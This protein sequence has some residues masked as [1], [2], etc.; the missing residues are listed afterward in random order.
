MSFDHNPTDLTSSQDVFASIEVAGAQY[1]AD[2]DSSSIQLSVSPAERMMQLKEEGVAT[3]KRL[4]IVLEEFCSHEFRFNELTSEVEYQGEALRP[5]YFEEAHHF[6]DEKVLGC[7]DKREHARSAIKYVS[8][9]NSY[10]PV[11]NYLNHVADTVHEEVTAEE[12]CER[13]LGNTHPLVIRYVECWLAGAVSKAVEGQGSKFIEVLTL[14]STLQGIGKS[15]FFK[16]LASPAWFSDSFAEHTG[17]DSILGLHSSWI[18]EI[19]EVD[20]Y[21]ARARDFKGLKSLVSATDDLVRVPYGTIIERR[22]RRFVLGATSNEPDLFST[23][24]QQRRFWVVEVNPTD[25]NGRLDMRWLEKNR[26]AIWA[27]ATRRYREL[28]EDAFKLTPAEQKQSILR[29]QSFCK[30][31]PIVDTISQALEEHNIR[32]VSVAEVAE[33]ILKD[34]KYRPAPIVAIL[35]ELGYEKKRSATKLGKK[36]ASL[37]EH[38]DRKVDFNPAVWQLREF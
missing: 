37:Y 31:S 18:T 20:Q 7:M 34:R 36:F 3:E 5:I 26:D 30:E 23:D 28:G 11:A 8:N 12:V 29:N 21:A 32:R 38:P 17:K 24:D 33:Y 6:L 27:T 9:K 13:C 16:V 10:H 4:R 1:V 35:R 19:S 22:P 25:G 15:Y 2:T 14:I